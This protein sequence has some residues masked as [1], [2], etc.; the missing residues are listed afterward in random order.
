MTDEQRQLLLDLQTS[1]QSAQKTLL[2][3]K[4]SQPA[5]TVEDCKYAIRDVDRALDIAISRA[6]YLK[7]IW[8]NVA[9][10]R[11]RRLQTTE[12]GTK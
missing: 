12:R 3:L 8:E 1:I 2:L 6:R 4:A 5:I 9:E 11:H 10:I 7:S